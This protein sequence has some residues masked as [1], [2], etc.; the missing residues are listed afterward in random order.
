LRSIVQAE[1]LI[2]IDSLLQDF[3]VRAKL[4]PEALFKQICSLSVGPLVT[5]EIGLEITDHALFR[6]ISTEFVELK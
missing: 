1:D 4:H 3:K 6:E 2:Y 5:Q